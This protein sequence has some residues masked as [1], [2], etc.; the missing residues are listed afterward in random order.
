[1]P[2]TLAEHKDFMTIRGANALRDAIIQYWHSRGH[3]GVSVQVVSRGFGSKTEFDVRSNL[4]NGLPR[5]VIREDLL[6]GTVT[7]RA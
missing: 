4:V 2:D 5:K 6:K 3:I 7:V 1:M